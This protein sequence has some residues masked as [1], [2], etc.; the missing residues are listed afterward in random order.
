MTQL[1][2]GNKA[3]DFRLTDQHGNN[4]KLGDFKGGRLLLYFYPKA[5]TSG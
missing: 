4:V 3:P 1:R 2:A 5:D